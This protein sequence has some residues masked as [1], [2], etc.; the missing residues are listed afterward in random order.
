MNAHALVDPYDT[1]I[2]FECT[3]STLEAS[4]KERGHSPSG[5]QWEALKDLVRTIENLSLGKTERKLF[6]SALDP[7]IGKTTSL[8]AFL[9][10]LLMFPH[11]PHSAVGVLVCISTK[12]EIETL[13]EEAAI[14]PEMLCVWTSEEELNALG[15]APADS[16]RVLIT[17]HSRMERLLSN[18]DFADCRE[19][20][21]N[22]KPRQLRVWDEQFLQG[23]PI[24]LN[25]DDVF[26]LLRA[27]SAI[28]RDLRNSVKAI[29]DQ[30]ETVE[31]GGLFTVPD[32]MSEHG[33][34]LD[35]LMSAVSD[36]E[37]NSEAQ[38]R[39]TDHQQ[40]ILTHLAVISG[41][42]V[43]VRKDGRNGAAAIDY[44]ETIPADL[45]PAVVLDASGRLR[46]TYEGMEKCR[47]ILKPLKSAAKCYRNL[48]VNI[49][50]RGGGK[51]AWK[52]P[53]KAASLVSGIVSTILTRPDEEWLVV[54]HK[55]ASKHFPEIDRLILDALPDDLH[56]RIKFITW[57]KHRGIND[58][59][60]VPNIILAG[61]LYLRDSQ[62]EALKRLSDGLRPEDG[63]VPDGELAR[64]ALGE[65]GDNILQALCR[66]AVR[67]S[68][69]DS[70]PPCRAYLVASARSGMAKA[71]EAI[72]PGCNVKAWR[73]VKAQL[74][75][76]ARRC[77]EYIAQW[78][79]T[80]KSGEVLPFRF[81]QSAL[82]A[83]RRHF[84]RDVR[85]NEGFKSA[86]ADLGVYEWGPNVRFTGWRM[87]ERLDSQAKVRLAA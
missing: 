16:A 60:D 18:C 33:V 47:G 72:F 53:S 46:L 86:I 85:D 55:K 76:N 35:D 15:S 57:G 37:Q 64:F 23:Q 42:S 73:P 48:E 44:L 66:G 81:A 71:V 25:V 22:G 62:Y 31:N 52:D 80:A 83:H 19:L 54:H 36:L 65:H 34:G 82:R 6:L 40:R 59:R 84:K 45:A 56:S 78:A 69:G 49:W 75:G 12:Q 41:H 10:T 63:T 29:F 11:E 4:F 9:D 70:C 67:K 61:M 74:N 43:R 51:T 77:F 21:F 2:L 87:G 14:P 5:E 30:I 17:T 26:W 3:L 1:S 58:H 20:Y 24:S 68:V 38:V 28:S 32:F 8:I 27:L 7:G 79:D 13:V 39:L 50:T